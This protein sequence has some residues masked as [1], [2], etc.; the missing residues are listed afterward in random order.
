MS[1]P[2]REPP[3]DTGTTA[4][5]QVELARWRVLEEFP[6][7]AGL[8]LRMP[9]VATREVQ[10][11]A[12]DH[13]GRLYYNPESFT[14]LPEDRQAGVV[15]HELLHLAFKHF[16]RARAAGVGPKGHER[17]NYAAD[18]EINPVV[19]TTF[20]LPMGALYP[21]RFGLPENELA[22]EYYA[23]LPRMEG[24]KGGSGEESPDRDE[25]RDPN[26][27]RPLPRMGTS[28]SAADGIPKHWELPADD[29][30]HPG[31]NETLIDTLITEAAR[32]YAENFQ[33]TKGPFSGRAFIEWV[34]QTLPRARVDWRSRL[35]RW[36]QSSLKHSAGADDY[37]FQR[38]RRR[39]PLIMPR[40]A[41]KKGRLALVIDTS[42]S[43]EK[44]DFEKVLAEVRD[45][46]RIAEDAYYFAVDVAVTAEG[47]VRSLRQIELRGGGFTDMTVG[48]KAAVDRGYESVIVL[49]D[50]GTGWPSAPEKEER[51]IAVLTQPTYYPEPPRWIETI[52]IK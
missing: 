28:G 13:H 9:L 27:S 44:E 16:A 30:E 25:D 43:M 45:I 48:I 7:L 36:V 22:E 10:I 4:R 47:P 24:P 17:W 5:E 46:L 52:Q 3:E 6:F 34:E 32:D 29:P 14:R 49:T 35:R 37:T 8:V 19:K 26:V 51:V 21:E 38:V 1:S 12:V 18:L 50:G 15:L 42:A 31:L 33:S 39:G 40:M 2:P 41:G 11:A 23:K 20:P